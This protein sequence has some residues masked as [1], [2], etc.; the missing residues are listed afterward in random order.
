MVIM[1]RIKIVLS[2]LDPY[3]EDPEGVLCELS[4]STGN[5][6]RVPCEMSS[7]RLQSSVWN[8]FLYIVCRSGERAV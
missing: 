8:G 5:P 1:Q 6:D 4:S 7:Q 3:P 2:E